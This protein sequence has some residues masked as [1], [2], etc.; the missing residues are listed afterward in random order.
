MTL[1]QVAGKY[2]DAA[3]LALRAFHLFGLD[4]PE[5]DDQAAAAFAAEEAREI[6]RVFGIRFSI[7]IAT[8]RLDRFGNF[9]RITARRAFERHMFEEMGKPLLFR[10]LV[11]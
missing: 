5:T 9:K 8:D 3:E 1:L 2:D 6:G 11:A 7:E 10:P 4:V